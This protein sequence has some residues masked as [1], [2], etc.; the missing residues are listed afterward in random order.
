[1]EKF[2]VQKLE[3]SGNSQLGDLVLKWLSDDLKERGPRQRRGA[4]GHEIVV[5][6]GRS[7][8]GR[9]YQDFKGKGGYGQETKAS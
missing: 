4:D 8:Q 7:A 5:R 1:M 9:T 2:E 6:D 3:L